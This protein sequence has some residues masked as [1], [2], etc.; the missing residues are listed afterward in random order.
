MAFD[1]AACRHLRLQPL[2]DV[3][4][5]G[6]YLCTSTA[7]LDAHDITNRIIR[8]K[9]YLID[10]ELLDLRV[11]LP[12]ALDRLIGGKVGRRIEGEGKG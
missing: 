2:H 9:N 4:A 11:P 5:C 1:G 10:K 7:E 6:N 3:E 12:P 8:Q